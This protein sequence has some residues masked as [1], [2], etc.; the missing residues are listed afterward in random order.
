[1]EEK[2][3]AAAEKGLELGKLGNFQK[4][5]QDF[6]SGIGTLALYWIGSFLIFDGKI[7]LGQLISF[8]TLSGFFL[9]PLKRLLTMQLHLQ[10]VMISAERLTDIIDMEEECADEENLEDVE[11]LDGDIEFKNV[12]FSYGTRGHAV[13]DISFVIPSGKKVAFVGSSGSGKTTLLKLLMKF[14]QLEEG[15]ILINGKD[16]SEIKTSSYRERIGYVPQESL[17]FSGTISENIAWGCN[18]PDSKKIVACSIAS[19]AYDFIQRLPEKFNTYVGE[20]GSTLSG[21]ERQRLAMARIL[22]RNPHMLILDE[23]TASLDSISEQAIMDTIFTRIK[24]RTVIMVAHRLSTIKDC[25]LIYVFD[26]GKLVEYGNHFEL[27]AKDSFYKNL[28]KAQNEKGN[29]S[30]TSKHDGL[31]KRIAAIESSIRD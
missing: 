22:M 15:Q 1:M 21:G 11:N 12:T 6:I 13:E 24:S 2:I 8:N 26:K 7:T 3:V 4:A 31:L 14:Y 29:G 27:L 17:L 16:I 28:W 5:I 30:S 9:G 25:D 18:N 23:A 20:H 10:E 19:Q